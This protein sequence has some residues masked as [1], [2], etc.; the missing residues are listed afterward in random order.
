MLSLL[1]FSWVNRVPLVSV[2]SLLSSSIRI[3]SLLPHER[4]N[5]EER[6]LHMLYVS[7]IRLVTLSDHFSY[8]QSSCVNASSISATID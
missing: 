3:Y 4:D 5:G 6:F 1:A 7:Y 2:L 8:L